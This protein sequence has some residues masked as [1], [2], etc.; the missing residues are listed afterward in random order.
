M[1]ILARRERRGAASRNRTY[2]EESSRTSRSGPLY[3]AA[4]P[5]GV[6]GGGLCAVTPTY[7]IHLTRNHRILT[8]IGCNCLGNRPNSTAQFLQLLTK[9][10]FL[11]RSTHRRRPPFPAPLHHRL[12]APECGGVCAC[13]IDALGVG[14][15]LDLWR[16]VSVWR[17][18]AWRCDGVVVCVC[19]VGHT[20]I[21][22][23]A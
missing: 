2:V 7:I 4:R 14:S 21:A 12:L 8:E 6:G 13:A 9:D 16:V 15:W 23:H 5:S 19:G 11:E 22:V 1:F 10:G 18:L 3:E 20:D 17:C